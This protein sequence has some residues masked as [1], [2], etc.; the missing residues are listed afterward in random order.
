MTAP[1]DAAALRALR[2]VPVVEIANAADALP[3]ARAL[4]AGGLPAMEITLRTPAALDAIAAVAD[5][6]PDFVLGAGT[7]LGP[8]DV[9]AAVQ[10]GA[11]FLVSPART[12]LLDDAARASGLMFVPGVSTATEALTAIDAGHRLLKFFPAEQ[13]GGAAGLRSLATP[14]RASGVGF[15][16]TGGIRPEN[17]VDYLAVPE[18]AAV[19]GTWIAPRDVVDS[20]DFAEVTARAAAAVRVAS[21]GEVAGA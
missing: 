5:S 11:R 12:T 16:P 1:I 18:V 19:G 2:V 6:L 10:A 20:G 3:L 14:L 8:L 15:M 21:T 13:S 7:L 9:E 17:L 4:M